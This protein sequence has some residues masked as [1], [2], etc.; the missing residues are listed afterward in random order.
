MTTA[1]RVLSNAPTVDVM[2][3]EMPVL[4]RYVSIMCDCTSTCMNV[5]DARR[6]LFTRKGRDIEAI[7]PPQMCYVDM[8]IGP[9]TRLATAGAIP[10]C[11]LL[12]LRV[13]VSGTLV[14]DNSP[15]T[16]E[17]YYMATIVR[18]L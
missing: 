5:N 7:P 14:D 4:E 8:Q 16:T 11:P 17:L 3:E 2:D 18:T 13:Q 15:G 10:W 9:R 12:H 6:H 1:F